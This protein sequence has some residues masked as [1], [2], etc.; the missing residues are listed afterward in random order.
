MVMPCGL[1]FV[2]ACTPSMNWREVRPAG[3]GVSIELPCK[4]STYARELRLQGAKTEWNIMACSAGGQTWALASGEL[5]DPALVA[6]AL[7]SLAATAR[8]NIA[9]DAAESLPWGP[10]GATPSAHSMRVRMRG[11]LPD[12]RTVTQVLAVFARGTRVFQA[13]VLGVEAAPEDLDTFF[14]SVRVL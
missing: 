13:S 9:A 3:A 1:I 10:R 6:P 4:P 2:V 8:A 11:T 12:G 14:T 5:N 7:Q